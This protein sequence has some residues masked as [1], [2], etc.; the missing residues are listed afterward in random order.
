MNYFQEYNW[1][2]E[3]VRLDS[4]A[5]K[6]TKIDMIAGLIVAEGKSKRFGSDKRFYE[7]DGKTFLEIAC[8]KISKVCDKN[9]IIIDKYFSDNQIN[10]EGFVTLRDLEDEKGPLIGIYSARSQ[11]T[12]EGCLVM[13]IDM[14][15]LSISFL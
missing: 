11:I 14:P 8:E 15:N 9:Y 2:F 1:N 6:S 3:G 10:L 7:L 5:W 13:P 12:D 4:A